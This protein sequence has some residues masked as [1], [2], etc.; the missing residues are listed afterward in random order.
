MS[1]DA[2]ESVCATVECLVEQVINTCLS[3][4]VSLNP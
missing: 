4:I 2:A 3:G 1:R